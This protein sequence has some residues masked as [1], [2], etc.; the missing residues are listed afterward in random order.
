M[1]GID[2]DL[3]ACR[4]TRHLKIQTDAVTK[5]TR[6]S[7]CADC[8][9]YLREG[10]RKTGHMSFDSR[11]TM[12]LQAES[13]IHLGSTQTAKNNSR[14]GNKNRVPERFRFGDIVVD[15]KPTSEDTNYTMV[16][17][18]QRESKSPF[19]NTSE[20]QTNANAT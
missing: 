7:L 2:I 6:T 4:N 10:I 12:T 20:E 18:V 9:L 11:C 1:K 15:M 3:T 16:A 14:A 19:E 17:R 8:Q 13:G 5:F